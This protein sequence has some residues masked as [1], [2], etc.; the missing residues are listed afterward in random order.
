MR[1]IDPV[2]AAYEHEKHRPRQAEA[3][4]TLQKIASLVKPIMRQRGW[5]VGVL[6][7][8]YP[9]EKN[10]LGLNWN[11]GEK[12]CLRLRYPYD[13][14][15]FIP[16]EEVV[17]TMLHEL[18]HI[19][20]GP[21]D[22]KFHALW[23]QLREEHERLTRKGYS[24]E[25]FLSEGKKLGGRRI[26]MDE[27]R[28]RA[29]ASAEQRRVLTQGSGQ[30]LGGASVL[31]GT[32][33]RRV[34]ADAASRRATVTGGCASGT[35]ESKGI[36]DQAAKN[37]FRTQAEEDDANEQAIIQAYI[38][39]IQEEE[40]EK[41]GDAYVPPSQDNP[42]GNAYS[43]QP[44]A[45]DTKSLPPP[46]QAQ[47]SLSQDVRPLSRLLDNLP[48]G[49]TSRVSHGR[50]PPSEEPPIDLTISDAPLEITDPVKRTWSC[51]ICTCDNPMNYLCCDACT[52]ERP[53][54]LTENLA[55]RT[56]S[57]SSNLTKS[58]SGSVGSTGHRSTRGG[59]SA[60][61]VSQPLGWVCHK[62]GTFMETQWWTC[63]SC[64]TMKLSS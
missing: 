50:K 19:A 30:R 63:S 4:T 22:Q 23:N 6:T 62:C 7:E 58:T 1:E 26:P 35:K 20:H 44:E 54:S 51:P 32:D 49:S 5:K 39:L 45:V 21:H 12:I 25:G 57:S 42:A 31:R 38:E 52:T 46:P 8:F 28:R 14:K 24:G 15:Q 34:I 43:N 29:R 40:K 2:I 55:T 59:I 27:A 3:L 36:M 60:A 37:G 10:L 18:A 61:D 13:E 17:D 64:G 9:P 53:E 48:I 11:G 16:M 47:P 33:M 41:W 56:A